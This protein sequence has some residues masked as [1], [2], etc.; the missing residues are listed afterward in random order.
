MR[1]HADE[2]PSRS[3]L[4]ALYRELIA[5]GAGASAARQP[6][7]CCV[8]ASVP[9]RARP[10]SAARWSRVLVELEL[11]GW[12]GTGPNR[13]L[14]A[15]S[16]SR[17]ELERSAAYIAYRRCSEEGRRFLSERRQS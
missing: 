9:T 7:R 12:N 11:A 4:A 17:T 3:S 2:W 14:W 13:S 6:G 8:A 1:V 16:S 10:R 15:V 5:T